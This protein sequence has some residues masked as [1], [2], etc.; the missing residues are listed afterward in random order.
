ML[1]TTLP[2]ASAAAAWAASGRDSQSLWTPAALL[3]ASVAAQPRQVFAPGHFRARVLRSSITANPSDGTVTSFWGVP[4]EGSKAG[5]TRREFFRQWA[6]LTTTAGGRSLFGSVVGDTLD[7]RVAENAAA[8]QQAVDA[9]PA[10]VGA[11]WSTTGVRNQQTTNTISSL[12]LA[13]VSFLAALLETGAGSLATQFGVSIFTLALISDRLGIDVGDVVSSGAFV[14]SVATSVGAAAI[15][16]FAGD[17]LGDLVDKVTSFFTEEDV[18]NAPDQ[19]RFTVL[20]NDPFLSVYMAVVAG[21]L[22]SEHLTFAY[23]LQ[24]HM[25]FASWLVGSGGY[26]LLQKESRANRF[27]RHVALARLYTFALWYYVS[28]VQLEWDSSLVWVEFRV[29]HE[30]RVS[31]DENVPGVPSITADPPPPRSL[32]PPPPQQTTA[33][34]PST[35][36]TAIVPRPTEVSGPTKRELQETVAA[37]FATIASIA[38]AANPGTWPIALPLYAGGLFLAARSGE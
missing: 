37:T 11:D 9:A 35:S 10:L 17:L 32:P 22:P 23:R 5:P 28:S 4:F 20:S 24:L 38:V 14:V 33:T 2:L 31:G 36:S 6:H 21:V 7:A 19:A 27:V 26:S 15:L 34:P 16:N 3:A 30:P 12:G 8:L 1:Q 18:A 29:G 25:N 13:E